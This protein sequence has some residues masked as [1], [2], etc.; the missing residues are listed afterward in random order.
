MCKIPIRLCNI[1]IIKNARKCEELNA[2]VQDTANWD[3]RQNLKLVG[4][5]EK[6]EAECVR[7]IIMEALQLQKISGYG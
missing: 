7:K 4:L 2:T 3:R 6:L 5:K 1:P